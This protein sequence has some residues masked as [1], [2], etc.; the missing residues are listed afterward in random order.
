MENQ[1]ENTT[2]VDAPAS[3]AERI[4]KRFG[5]IAALAKALGHK[6]SSTVQGWKK[7]GIIRPI[8]N[9]EILNAAGERNI[10]LQPGDFITV[11]PEHAYFQGAT[12]TPVQPQEA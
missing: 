11:D 8:Y 1:I 7:A 10:A 6:N 9:D 2:D 5:G 4:I 12:V 3:Q